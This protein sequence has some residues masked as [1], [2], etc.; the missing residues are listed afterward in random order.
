MARKPTPTRSCRAIRYTD[1][2]IGALQALERGDATPEQQKRALKWIV[3]EAGRRD[4]DA[5]LLE[6]EGGERA[7]AFMAGRRFVALEILKL[8]HLSRSA[9]DALLKKVQ[10]G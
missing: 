8:V 3:E 2:E 6:P 1:A 5:F 10:D 4:S 7:S 9:R